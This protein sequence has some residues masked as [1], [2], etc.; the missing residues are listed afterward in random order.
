MNRIHEAAAGIL[1]L[2]LV[3]CTAQNPTIDKSTRD[4]GP[5]VLGASCPTAITGEM[6]VKF[7]S[8]ATK[9][10]T[11]AS[12]SGASA[13]EMGSLPEQMQD[14]L[15]EAG[16]VTFERLF[17]PD[18]RFEE[19]TRAEGLDRWYMVK[20]DGEME[21]AE[22]AAR[23]E[24]VEGIEVIECSLPL[25]SDYEDCPDA[26]AFDTKG[27]VAAVSPFNDP[28]V[29]QMR[30]W[31]FNNTGIVANISTVAGADCNVYRA[32]ELCTGNRDVIVG[33]FDQGVKY[34]H[35]D[36]AANMWVNEGE[37]P[38]NLLDDDGNG[39]VDDIYG[40]NFV[41]NTPEI[42]FSNAKSHGTHIAGT[43]SAVNNN[44]I[45]VCGIAGGSGKGDGVRIMSLQMLGASESG[46][47]GAGTSGK[48]RAMKYA[49]DNGAV[50]SS[51]SW[52][53]DTGSISLETWKFGIYSAYTDAVKY[54]VKYAGIGA[55]GT[56]TGPMAGGIVVCSAGN[57]ATADLLHYPSC[58][59]NVIAVAATGMRGTP[60]S[61]TNYATWVTVSAPGGNASDNSAYGQIYSLNI[62]DDEAGSSAYGYKQGTSMACPHVSGALALAVSYYWGEEHNQGLTP[63]M[64]KNALISSSKDVNQYCDEQYYGKMGIGALDTYNLLRAVKMLD[65]ALPDVTLAVGGEQTIDLSGYFISTH[66]FNCTVYDDSVVSASI[67]RGVLTLKGL[68]KGETR[69]TVSDAKAIGKDMKV[70]VN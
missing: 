6:L 48:I 1:A 37:I 56:Q 69:I 26:P 64:L 66:S 70:T 15:E 50:I 30:Q 22:M 58:D 55:D 35:E 3:A 7:T 16:T 38:G 20:Y 25:T 60:A 34:D 42:T 46:A 23:L 8:T 31:D 11:K 27:S 2:A 19:R 68:K 13:V 49:A 5:V 44:G 57:D 61:Y 47:A 51:N 39:Y 36:L 45:G 53:Y 63:V 43:I 12:D 17:T 62:A 24:S 14:V 10:M 59:P 21:P 41:D 32:W 28:Y 9:A 18:P 40:W 54:F 67:S 52:G 33:V 65:V 29:N 4:S